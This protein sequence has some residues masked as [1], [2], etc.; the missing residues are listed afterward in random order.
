MSYYNNNLSV[1]YFDFV[2]QDIGMDSI[3]MYEN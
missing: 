3:Q 1:Y 2:D